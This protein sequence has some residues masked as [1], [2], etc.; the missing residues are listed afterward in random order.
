MATLKPRLTKQAGYQRAWASLCRLASFEVKILL[1]DR[2]VKGGN[3]TIT[4][5]RARA[6]PTSYAKRC[7]KGA[8][9]CAGHWQEVHM[10]AE[11][12]RLNWRWRQAS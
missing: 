7:P 8:N 5:V 4:F 3:L 10:Q 1:A 9:S 2:V 12:H 11:R 6:F